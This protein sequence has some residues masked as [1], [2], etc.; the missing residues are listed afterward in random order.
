[1]SDADTLKLHV[2]DPAMQHHVRVLIEAAIKSDQKIL[3][4][5]FKAM[6]ENGGLLED[7]SNAFWSSSHFSD[8]HKMMAIEIRF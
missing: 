8:S 2:Y 6:T 3:P 5:V 7:V 4:A 1:M